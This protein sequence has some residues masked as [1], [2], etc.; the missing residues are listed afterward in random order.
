MTDPLIQHIQ[1]RIHEAGYPTLQSFAEKSGIRAAT[2]TR[3]FEGQSRPSRKS[4]EK[5]A[6]A[7]EC[8]VEDFTDIAAE[9]PSFADKDRAIE[10]LEKLVELQDRLIAKLERLLFHR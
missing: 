1:R 6:A 4:L 2:L 3:W 7:L 8:S 10:R 9:A 5:L